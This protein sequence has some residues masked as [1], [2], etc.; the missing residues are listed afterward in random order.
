M[1]GSAQISLCGR[2]RYALDRWVDGRERWVDG[3][4]RFVGWVLCNPSTADAMVDDRTVLKGWG[5]TER[6]GGYRMRFCNTNPYR[7]TDPDSQI[8]PPEH[9]LAQNDAAILEM[10]ESASLIICAW[11]AKA[12]PELARRAYALLCGVGKPLHALVL[13]KDG[14][15]R[16]P[17]YLP[18]RLEPAPWYGESEPWF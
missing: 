4:E 11:G 8:L 2:Y 15:P 3:R 7:S 18:S 16:H 9:V 5:F 1:Q 6:A 14:I 13:T 17:L 10:A 12:Y